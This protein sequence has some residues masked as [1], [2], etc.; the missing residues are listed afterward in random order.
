MTIAPYVNHLV[1]RD[2]MM[3]RIN[4][5]LHVVA[6]DAGDCRWS[7]SNV[8]QYRGAIS[9]LHQQRLKVDYRL[10]IVRTSV[11]VRFGDQTHRSR[12]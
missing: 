10:V 3:L 12:R 2:E 4:R 1:S 9:A 6:N 11:V 7:P 5:N 8:H